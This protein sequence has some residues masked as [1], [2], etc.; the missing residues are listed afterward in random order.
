M[1]L[2]HNS[3]S[4]IEGLNNLKQLQRLDLSYNKITKLSGLS[5]CKALIHLDL[6]FNS[7]S[8]LNCLTDLNLLTELKNLNLLGNALC[9]K[10]DKENVD[11]Q[12]FKKIRDSYFMFVKK[13]LPNLRFLDKEPLIWFNDIVG[14]GFWEQK[15]KIKEKEITDSKIL[16][17][18][19]ASKELQ[20]ETTQEAKRK[21]LESEKENEG[22]FNNMKKLIVESKKTISRADEL[23]SEVESVLEVKKM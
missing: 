10:E 6:S 1:N 17:F 22:V 2:S 4:K 14:D 13:Q 21:I 12:N 19:R 3:I 11:T 20:F 9:P 16:S 7:L 15:I 5:T 18:D 8:D 23:I